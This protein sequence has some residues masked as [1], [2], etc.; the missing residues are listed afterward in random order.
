MSSVST[1][2]KLGIAAR[3][4]G[5]VISQHARRT[6]TFG[7]VTTAARATAS[8]FG[9]VLGQLWL[10]VTGF[11]FLVLAGIGVIAFWREYAKYQAGHATS[12]R[13]LL[14]ACFSGLF[15]WFGVTSFLQVRKRSQNR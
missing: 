10:E 1:S 11:V 13:A 9:R 6:R 8:H 7:A 15:G 5:R 12:S 4:A 2:R 14:A 3:V